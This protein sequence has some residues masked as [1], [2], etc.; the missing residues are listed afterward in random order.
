MSP[1]VPFGR[2]LVVGGKTE[3]RLSQ[4]GPPP[5]ERMANLASDVLGASEA[6]A[7]EISNFFQLVSMP[8]T[9]PTAKVLDPSTLS[10]LTSRFWSLRHFA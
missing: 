6:V 9:E 7:N 10:K 5:A 1:R 4:T 8:D 2:L 3:T